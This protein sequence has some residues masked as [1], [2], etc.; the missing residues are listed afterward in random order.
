MKFDL[1]WIKDSNDFLKQKKKE[2]ERKAMYCAEE[3]FQN[4]AFA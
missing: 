4:G 1:Q 2:K 3:A